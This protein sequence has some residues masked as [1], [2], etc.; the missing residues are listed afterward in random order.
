MHKDLFV[1]SGPFQTIHSIIYFSNDFQLILVSK[2]KYDFAFPL[3]KTHDYYCSS[4][5]FK[6]NK[7]NF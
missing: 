1:N 6:G 3:M 4:F 7:S 2:Q 5:L